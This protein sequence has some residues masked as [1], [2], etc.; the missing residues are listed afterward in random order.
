[1]QPL[2]NYSERPYN[3]A[4][5]VIILYS[6]LGYFVRASVVQVGSNVEQAL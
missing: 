2:N 4:P 5:Q 3:T 6:G 1:M